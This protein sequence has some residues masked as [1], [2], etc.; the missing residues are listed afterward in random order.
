MILTN[1]D[2]LKFT[3]SGHDSFQCRQ[4]WLKKGYDFVQEEQSFN[5]ED[6]VVKLGVGKNMVSA[7]RYWMKA[8]N[9]ID[10]KD[11]L[12]KFGI[13]I[14]DTESGYDPFLEDEASLWLLHYQLIKTG[15]ASIYTIIFN[16]FRKEKLF[17]TKETF[18]NYLKRI[19]EANP[20]LNFNENTVAK[21]FSVFL[22]MYKNDEGGNEV[23]DSFSGILSEIGL[24]KQI[25]KGKDEQFQIENNERDGL[26]DA[27]M[28]FS[29]L[30]NS[31]F[32][33]S[34][35]LN[36]LEFDT[37]SP[38][39]IFAL[40]RS[41]LVNKISDIVSDS[42]NITFTDHAGIKE[43]QFKNKPDAY[44]VLDKYYGK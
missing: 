36:S 6:A 13:K 42:K 8:F 21:D 23:E 37:N 43:L 5:N 32:G 24:L 40:N 35:S 16:E 38:G 31:N 15:L 28:L 44:S 25:G 18:L 39:S 17:F 33:N 3:F 19:Q 12:T 20:E 7:I 14:F 9:I 34:I 4:L 30:D 41:G 1:S 11:K 10:N 26:P 2:I 22:N 27:V 29:I